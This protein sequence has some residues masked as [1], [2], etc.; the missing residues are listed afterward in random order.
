MQTVIGRRRTLRCRLVWS[1]EAFAQRSSFVCVL[2]SACLACELWEGCVGV[3]APAA[4]RAPCNASVY[5]RRCVGG[6][7][8]GYSSVTQHWY[9]WC[10]CRQASVV[11]LCQIGMK[12]EVLMKMFMG[13]AAESTRS[14][15]VHTGQW[16]Q[17]CA[18]GGVC[19][20]HTCVALGSER[21]GECW[22]EA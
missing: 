9:G 2:F 20:S 15:L 18:K 11:N 13:E 3:R 1:T 16:T 10:V 21:R 8:L 4:C 14:W 5:C 19:A 17:E 12:Q 22:G 7:S 6:A